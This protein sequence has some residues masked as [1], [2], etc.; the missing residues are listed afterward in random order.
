MQVGE[1]VA[2]SYCGVV[3]LLGIVGLLVMFRSG[4]VESVGLDTEMR[5]YTLGY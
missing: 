5:D 4:R 2:A 1:I 3:V